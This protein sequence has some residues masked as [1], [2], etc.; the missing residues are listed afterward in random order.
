MSGVVKLLKL[1]L[2]SCFY[3]VFLGV[4][5]VNASQ[6]EGSYDVTGLATY[7]KVF[8]KTIGNSNS[9][10]K[11]NIS[12]Q[13]GI[14]GIDNDLPNAYKAL[15]FE[16]TNNR[17]NGSEQSYAALI[18]IKRYLQ[19]NPLDK[20]DLFAKLVNEMIYRAEVSPSA[21]GS[22]GKLN[23]WAE[24]IGFD[25]STVVSRN[26]EAQACG[27]VEML[28]SRQSLS[29]SESQS[30][31]VPSFDLDESFSDL[32][33]LGIPWDVSCHSFNMSKVHEAGLPLVNS[34]FDK[35]AALKIS[36][37]VRNQLGFE[38]RPVDPNS[39]S[40][41]SDF[42]FQKGVQ[43]PGKD[44]FVEVSYTD[45]TDQDKLSKF[46]E[47][48]SRVLQLYLNKPSKANSQIELGEGNCIVLSK[49]NGFI[50]DKTKAYYYQSVTNPGILN[51]AIQGK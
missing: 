29:E 35:K 47:S 1:K 48:I 16:I 27:L 31:E 40:R 39:N 25:L 38:R 3:L 20:N 34:E 49:Y 2:F 43:I 50:T 36:E 44:L 17:S 24:N 7:K 21:D 30:G 10:T 46:Q 22:L 15:E 45:C 9:V 18:L 28:V 23:D 42:V 5:S 11:L 4:V 26:G 13:L 8:D 51:K 19:E 33:S 6:E 32:V 14:G 37:L 41:A 12:S